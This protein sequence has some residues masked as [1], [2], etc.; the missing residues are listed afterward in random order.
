MNKKWVKWAVGV[1]SITAFSGIIAILQEAQNDDNNEVQAHATNDFWNVNEGNTDLSNLKSNE[2]E[3]RE[4]FIAGLDW[5]DSEWN[6][7]T[8]NSEALYL[9]PSDQNQGQVQ[10]NNRTERS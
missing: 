5:N 1:G 7:D 4:K 9:T 10:R 2:K 6:V 8:T 3:E